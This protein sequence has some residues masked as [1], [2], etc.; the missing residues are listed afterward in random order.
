MQLSFLTGCSTAP[1]IDSRRY[2]IVAVPA[3]HPH[4]RAAVGL[5]LGLAFPAHQA[6][7]V[8][9]RTRADIEACADERFVDVRLDLEPA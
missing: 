1:T 6:R 7:E 4:A 8:L 2:R 5:A 3:D 9:D